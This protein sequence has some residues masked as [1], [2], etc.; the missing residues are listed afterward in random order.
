MDGTHTDIARSAGARR[1]L[2]GSRNV[3]VIV[4]SVCVGGWGWGNPQGSRHFC[5]YFKGSRRGSQNV[6]VIVGVLEGGGRG[7]AARTKLESR[8]FCRY[9]KC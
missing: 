2:K 5:R 6:F 8:S 9:L 7:R 4:S 1:I 3:C